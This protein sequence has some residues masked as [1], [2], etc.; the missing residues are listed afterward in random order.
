MLKRHFYTQ[1]LF[2]LCLL[3]MLAAVM[4]AHAQQGINTPIGTVTPLPPPP[5]TITLPEGSAPL[6]VAPPSQS[7]STGAAT[8]FAPAPEACDLA[9]DSYLTD[10]IDAQATLFVSYDDI[11]YNNQD[12]ELVWYALHV[13]V[14]MLQTQELPNALW[15]VPMS[16][17][18]QTSIIAMLPHGTVV[19]VFGESTCLNLG[20]ATLRLWNVSLGDLAGWAI[21][22]IHIHEPIDLS[23]SWE[24]I[25]NTE[26]PNQTLAQPDLPVLVDGVVIRYLMPT[27]IEPLPTP[28]GVA[29]S[30]AA[31]PACPDSVP[32]YLAVGMSVE[33]SGFGYRMLQDTNTALPLTEEGWAL[34]TEGYENYGLM[35][36]PPIPFEPSTFDAVI[37]PAT[38]YS[39]TIAPLATV[40]EGPVCT[41]GSLLSDSLDVQE[42]TPNA[43]FIWWKIRVPIGNTVYEG[44]YMEGVRVAA[45]WEFFPKLYYLYYMTPVSAM[46]ASAS[47]TC[48]PSRLVAGQ[49]VHPIGALNLRTAPNGD[50]IGRVAAGQAVSLLDT[51][52]CVGGANWWRTTAGGFLAE[53]DPTVPTYSA[54]L[55]PAVQ[56]LVPTEEAAPTEPTVQPTV[57]VDSLLPTLPPEATRE[58][59]S[60]LP[61]L[62]P[63]IAVT[64]QPT[65]T[66]PPR[67]N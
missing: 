18:S 63:L 47:A 7:P 1:R 44:W 17:G 65:P 29:D 20:W 13:A 27:I 37:D 62:V 66:R 2:W 22:S 24:A 50:V 52:T 3:L 67:S 40:L 21:E 35:Q 11:V 57:F 32:S 58:P 25:P 51:P 54:L 30:I 5:F 16:E 60:A 42:Y 59:S 33:L 39:P 43:K 53:N 23:S 56:A 12:P 15:S 38:L 8:D 31:A 28:I 4:S 45:Y 26:N 48:P 36:T 14:A 49:S 55:L 46:Q 61:T 41:E 9:A 10:G 64:V 19:G 6:D 34:W